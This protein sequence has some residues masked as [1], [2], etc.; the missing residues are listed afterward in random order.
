MADSPAHRAVE[1][2]DLAELR[3]LLDGGADVQD[4]TETG[5]TLLHHSVD[6]EIDGAQQNN[7]PVHVDTTALLLA[8]GA[9]PLAA[10][11]AGLTPLE[12]ARRRGHW[13]AAILMEGWL[14]R[15]P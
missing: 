11:G 12:S 5:W 15:T 14:S 4:P 2:E 9:N 13:L 8:K 10:D 3:R 6:I 1:L 7:E